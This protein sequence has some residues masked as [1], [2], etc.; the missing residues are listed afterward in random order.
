MPPSVFDL[1]PDEYIIK[2]GKVLKLTLTKDNDK[3][4]KR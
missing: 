2:D 1:E 3:K 4:L